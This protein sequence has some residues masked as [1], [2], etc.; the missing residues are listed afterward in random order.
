MSDENADGLAKRFATD[1]A[2]IMRG[3]VAGSLLER[4]EAA[5]EANLADPSELA[6]VAS[7]DDD[8]GRFVEDFCN[9]ERFDEYVALARHVARW[10]AT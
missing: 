2:V 5:V 10:W 1:G 8:P 7:G 3:V 6:I 4:V 9:W